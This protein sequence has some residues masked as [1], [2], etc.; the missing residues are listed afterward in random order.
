MKVTDVPLRMMVTVGLIL[1]LT[2]CGG[3]DQARSEMTG[4]ELAGEVGCLACHGGADTGTAPSLD[5]IWGT[6]VELSD[7][8][9]VTVDDAYVRRSITDPG[10]DIVAG[11][12]AIMPVFPLEPD[13]VDRLVDWVRSLA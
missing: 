1:A 4:A 9:T 10:A 11:Y 2:A 12:N 6:D 3:S 7:G 5:G 8:R 13:E